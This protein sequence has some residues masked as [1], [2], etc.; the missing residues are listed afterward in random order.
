M[1]ISI[2]TALNVAFQNFTVNFSGKGT[3]QIAFACK[4]K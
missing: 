3:G 2:A 1:K 4:Y